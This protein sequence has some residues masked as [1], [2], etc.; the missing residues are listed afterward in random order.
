MYVNAPPAHRPT[1][2][3]L[4]YTGGF[5]LGA[6][7]EIAVQLTHCYKHDR[8]GVFYVEF[9]FQCES[10]G[11]DVKILFEVNDRIITA[12]QVEI[13]LAGFK[14]IYFTEQ[15]QTYIIIDFHTITKGGVLGRYE[16]LVILKR[17]PELDLIK[18]NPMYCP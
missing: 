8:R 13:E 15:K 18:I 2:K 12:N 7:E 9:S 14:S 3:L 1:I 5:N 4:K 16:F 11:D 6:K 17:D 10:N